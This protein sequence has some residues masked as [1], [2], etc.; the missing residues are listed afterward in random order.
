VPSVPC[1]KNFTARLRSFISLRDLS[2]VYTNYVVWHEITA[3]FWCV[4]KRAASR[5]KVVVYVLSDQKASSCGLWNVLRTSS[6]DPAVLLRCCELE[7]LFTVF[8]S[9]RCATGD[10]HDRVA[11]AFIWIEPMKVIPRL[12]SVGTV[13]MILATRRSW[14]I[15]SETEIIKKEQNFFLNVLL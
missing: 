13:K 1:L 14:C 8:N 7:L 2:V 10:H 11:A 15:Q 6:I 12:P 5:V 9:F 4:G 3:R